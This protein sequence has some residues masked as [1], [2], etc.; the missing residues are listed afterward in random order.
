M[1]R[2]SSFACE[3]CAEIHT[4]HEWVFILED[5]TCRSLGADQAKA[6]SERQQTKTLDEMTPRAFDSMVARVRNRPRS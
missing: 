2:V 5:L 1:I 6:C 3:L 4:A